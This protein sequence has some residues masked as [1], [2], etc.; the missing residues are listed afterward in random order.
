MIFSP[1]PK[2]VCRHIAQGHRFVPGSA[3][4]PKAIKLA[5]VVWG[6]YSRVRRKTPIKLHKYMKL[7]AR[8]GQFL[9]R[10]RF[11]ASEAVDFWHHLIKNI[12]ETR[13]RFA[14]SNCSWGP[15]FQTVYWPYV[16]QTENKEIPLSLPQRSNLEKC[17][18]EPRIHF[19]R[20]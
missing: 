8:A 5:G 15:S 12:I 10:S 3:R 20:T 13:G 11:L 4:F 18:W 2:C 19:F 7:I 16:R 6:K 14:Q 1:L 17:E 9:V